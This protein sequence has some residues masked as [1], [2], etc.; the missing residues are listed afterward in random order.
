MLSVEGVIAYGQASEF[1]RGN[2]ILCDKIPV[3]TID[4][5]HRP[6][7]M[8]LDISLFE[9]LSGKARCSHNKHPCEEQ[10]RAYHISCEMKTT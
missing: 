2:L 1:V 3:S 5:H 9:K 6:F 8:F 7:E 4:L 10:A